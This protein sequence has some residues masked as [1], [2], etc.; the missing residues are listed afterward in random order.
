MHKRKVD[1]S[2]GFDPSVEAYCWPAPGASP[3]RRAL[4]QYMPVPARVMA[5]LPL[6]TFRRCV[7]RYRGER[8]VE[9]VSCLDRFP[10][11]AFALPAHAQWRIVSDQ[12]REKLPK[13]AAMMDVA[14]HEVLTFMDFPK[15]HRVKIHSINVLER[16]NGEIRRRGDVVGISPNEAAIRRL[17]GALLLEQNDENAIQKRYMSLESLAAMSENPP[18]RL[19]AAPALA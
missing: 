8:K 12:L 11:M 13:L 5:H 6:S 1:V 17:A 18:I 9:S 10:A 14:E 7:A 16:L 2:R 3:E 4:H 19:P 15:E